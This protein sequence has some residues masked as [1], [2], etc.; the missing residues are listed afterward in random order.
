M[1][2]R[3]AGKTLLEEVAAKITDET[4]RKAFL[5][6]ATDDVLDHLGDAGLR[7]SDFTKDKNTLAEERRALEAQMAANVR[8]HKEQS[9][10]LEHLK[11]LLQVAGTDDYEEV[12]RKLSGV[13]TPPPGGDDEEIAPKTKAE[14]TAIRKELE[15]FEAL[16]KEVTDLQT[17]GAALIGVMGEL[18]DQFR[19]DFGKRL[20]RNAVYAH[21][22]KLQTDV[23]SAYNDLY[24]EE[25][26]GIAKKKHDDEIEAAE[27][28]GQ[29]RA[30]REA[31]ARLPHVVDTQ[32]PST[33]SGLKTKDGDPARAAIKAAIDDYQSGKY[34]TGAET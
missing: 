7:Q 26:A 20:D 13:G 27:K 11:E 29:E 18:G 6:A 23:R 21:A 15:K 33:L 10:H 9:G 17:N 14:L 8:W 30:L 5:A 22:A 34:R 16:K 28:R 32:E 19:E 3:E 31:G 2:R 25:Y 4:A 12:K 24:K 1:A